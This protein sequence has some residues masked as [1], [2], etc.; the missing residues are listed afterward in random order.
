MKNRIKRF[1]VTSIVVGIAWAIAKAIAKK[2][3]Q[4]RLS[5]SCTDDVCGL[6]E[7]HIKRP[8]VKGR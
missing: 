6:S 4:V 1:V 5:A 2:T 3:S 7:A 8:Y